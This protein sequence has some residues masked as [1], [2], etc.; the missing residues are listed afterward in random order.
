MK[1]TSLPTE[2]GF[3]LPAEFE[4]QQAGYMIWPQ[5]PDNW[6]DGGKPAQQAFAKLAA[7]L[8]KYQPMTMLVNESQFKNARAMLPDSVRV[9]EMSSNDAFIK[10][11]GPF[12][13]VNNTGEI[14]Y[15]D[16]NFNAWGGLLD[17]LY[18]PWDKDNELGMKLA[19][20]NRL[21]LYQ[22]PMTLEG[23]S[24]LTDGEGTLFTTEEVILSEGRNK[25]MTKE[26]AETIFRDY[27][28]I[29]KTIWLPEGFFMDETGGDI[30]NVINVVKPGELVLSWTDNKYDPQYR[31]SHE[32]LELLQQATDAKGRH[33]KIHKL[34]LPST[35]TLSAKEAEG[36]D[37]INGMLPRIEG[38]RLTAT[39][40]NYITT[41]KAIV[42][43]VFDDIQDDQA[44]Q[45]L[46][47]LY[48]DRL[49]ETY[50]ARE[51]LTGGGGLHTVVL[52][53]PSGQVGGMK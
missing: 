46:H 47:E 27:L 2:D 52:N 22:N 18:F 53:V 16:F 29:S 28:G 4:S 1:L 40:V 39:Y 21:D 42:V 20:L 15:A 35:L 8:A 48:P 34:Q 50:P 49:V 3:R 45:L 12:Y 26:A 36:V 30:D 43:P 51:I 24:V 19:D 31:I 13:I 14:R 7:L 41:D 23:C 25:G 44:C 38:Q 32:A 5:R 33:F 9:I 17:G 37:P 10:D 6:R 11:T